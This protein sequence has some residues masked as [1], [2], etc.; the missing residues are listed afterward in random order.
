MPDEPAAGSP[1]SRL[2]ATLA[3]MERAR[4][5]C[6][7]TGADSPRLRKSKRDATILRARVE[8]KSLREAGAL[9]GVSEA[10]ACRVAQRHE[11]WLA[12]E[13]RKWQR[14]V[15]KGFDA[16]VRARVKDAGNPESRT[17][18]AS[19]RELREVLGWVPRNDVHIGDVNLDASTSVAV[20]ARQQVVLTPEQLEEYRRLRA[21]LA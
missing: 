10:T 13:R 6:P 12:E 5:S 15:L 18:A 11:E 14:K 3:S 7:A 4:T 8:G 20:D 21:E 1:T 17:G 2:R 16:P 9:A 19:F